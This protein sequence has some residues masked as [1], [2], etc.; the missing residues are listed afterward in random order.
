MHRGPDSVKDSQRMLRLG[1]LR[2]HPE[3]PEEQEPKNTLTIVSK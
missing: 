2:R 3:E 1:E